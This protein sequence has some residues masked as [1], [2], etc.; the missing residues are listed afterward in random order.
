[1][2]PARHSRRPDSA[3]VP[4]TTGTPQWDSQQVCWHGGVS[5]LPSSSQPHEGQFCITDSILKMRNW[6]LRE[7]DS[8]VKVTQ[9]GG[10]GADLGLTVKRAL[11]AITGPSPR[12]TPYSSQNGPRRGGVPSPPENKLLG[13]LSLARPGQRTRAST[14]QSPELQEPAVTL[15]FR[16]E[17]RHSGTPVGSLVRFR[18]PG[19]QGRGEGHEAQTRAWECQRGDELDRWLLGQPGAPRGH[20]RRSGTEP[21]RPGCPHL[22]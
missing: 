7:L 12:V 5:R 8:L 2:N 21:A 6:S 13:H 14:P 1:M 16:S 9:P 15:Q 11:L 10:S 18:V 19:G 22:L 20:N 4:F 17:G 3:F